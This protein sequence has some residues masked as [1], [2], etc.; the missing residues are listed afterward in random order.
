MA[1]WTT[2]GL[3]R[4]S[5]WFGCVLVITAGCTSAPSPV[6][7]TSPTTTPI[8]SAAAST[9]PTS[10]PTAGQTPVGVVGEFE[11]QQVGSFDST[12]MQIGMAAS[13]AGYVV[14]TFDGVWFSADGRAWLKSKLP[15][16]NGT[17]NGAP[18][19]AQANA[20][21]G[22]PGG[23]VVVGGQSVKPCDHVD[24]GAGG[25][26]QC[27]VAPISWASSDGITWKSSLPNP[28]PATGARLP[29]Y[30]ELV[31]IWPADGG[32]DAAAEARAS[33]SYS[34]NSLLHSDDGLVWTSR[35]SAPLPDGASSGRD[36]NAHGGVSSA[37]GTRLLW[38][39]TEIGATY[40]P[41]SELA[42]TV[43]GT[44]WSK[45][46]GFVGTGAIVRFGLAPEA[47]NA[48]QWLLIGNGS[49]QVVT[50]WQSDDL[51]TWRSGPMTAAGSPIQAIFSL[52]RWAGGYIALGSQDD[53]SYPGV[54]GT[55][56]SD[57]G[58]QWRSA[59]FVGPE[60]TNGPILMADGPAG[61][62]GVGSDD[63]GSST[64]VGVDPR[65]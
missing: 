4:R 8:P 30:T 57:D 65:R 34:G 62:I 60:P 14:L 10:N 17:S 22:G 35:K 15:F 1:T 33:V 54:P 51:A 16:P 9:I 46:P 45:V 52:G 43:D 26:P 24:E 3:R 56:L 7:A 44:S 42:T 6:P 48:A 36:V 37:N 40:A 61:L 49:N 63:S 2:T 5:M 19:T 32:W 41:R 20:I 28:I 59:G 47:T 12:P 38:Q 39:Y 18:L 55:F 27:L 58:P 23:F 64:W 29:E 21:A 31:S 25:P 53:E 11:W 13:P 50:W